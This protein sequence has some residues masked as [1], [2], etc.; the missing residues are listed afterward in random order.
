[1]KVIKEFLFG[2]NQLKQNLQRAADN[3]AWAEL[4]TQ[5][6]KD[7]RKFRD[8]KR[9]TTAP[10]KFGLVK[11]I[12]QMFDNKNVQPNQVELITIKRNLQ[13]ADPNVL[14]AVDKVAKS[15]GWPKEFLLGHLYAEAGGDGLMNKR[16]RSKVGAQGPMQIMPNT[17]KHF[18][19]K[20]PDDPYESVAGAAEI[21]D[22][23]T[24][25]FQGDLKDGLQAYN[26]GPT[27][28]RQ[29]KAGQRQMPSETQH[30]ADK[31]AKYALAFKKIFKG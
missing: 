23:Y 1:M 7:A 22:T 16:V 28:L 26:Q 19:I 25:M 14:D 24:K 6:L 29:V 31:V 8:H 3:K 20:N 30:Y 2:N 15:K 4:Q 27:A 13:K 12:K 11:F 10:V 5:R 18:K 21:L 17:A 9:M